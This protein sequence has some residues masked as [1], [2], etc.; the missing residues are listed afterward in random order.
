MTPLTETAAEYINAGLHVLALRHKRPNTRF[1]Q[2][3]SWDDSMHGTVQSAEDIEGL[4]AVFD[5]PSTTGVA[6][7]VPQHILVAD[8]DTEA[9]AMLFL[10]LAGGFPDTALAKT[11]R[12]LHIW[13]YAPGA[14]RSVWIGGSTLLLKGLHG[15]VAA[16][17]SRHFD[18][19]GVEDGVYT[20]IEP[21]VKN[22]SVRGID[23]LPERMVGAIEA[24]AQAATVA[25]RVTREAFN[26]V[27]MV[28]V[29]SLRAGTLRFESIYLLDG[30]MQAIREAPDGNQ[31]SII[32]WATCRAM[33]EGVPYAVTSEKLLQAAIEGGHPRGRAKATIDGVFKRQRRR[34]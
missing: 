23:Y 16:P 3:W 28:P 21:L 12:G 20:W 5:H 24:E 22:G 31:N 10:G 19:D 29:G 8:V 14:D 6:I 25:P 33:E 15:Y 7:L 11:P 34:G 9:A 17:P 1:H 27:R 32:H 30:L 13:Y 26:P 2:Q 4:A 18:E